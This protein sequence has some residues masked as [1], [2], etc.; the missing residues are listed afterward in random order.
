RIEQLLN[1]A[2]IINGSVIEDRVP[3]QPRLD[4]L[5]KYSG[6][7]FLGRL[8]RAIVLM[9]YRQLLP[10][11]Q[12][13]WRHQ[14]SINGLILA[15]NHELLRRL[16]EG[17]ATIRKQD[18]RMAWPVGEFLKTQTQAPALKIYSEESVARAA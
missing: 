8:G 14:F 9:A 18:D 11:I 13:P 3:P 5:I 12:T 17:E 4:A 6:A 2:A 15:Q 16:R 1:S 7:Q 10:L